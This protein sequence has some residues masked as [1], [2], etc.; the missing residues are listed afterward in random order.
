[1][2]CLC[3]KKSWKGHFESHCCAL[4]AAFVY[5]GEAALVRSLERRK[6]AAQS[7]SMTTI[8]DFLCFSTKDKR[9]YSGS[10]LD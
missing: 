5:S 2:F 8:G 7:S 6:F 1:M 9:S 3:H 4:T 10:A